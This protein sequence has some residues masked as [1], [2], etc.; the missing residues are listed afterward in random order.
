MNRATL[1]KSREHAG[2]SAHQ[3]GIHEQCATA[4]AGSLRISF[5]RLRETHDFVGGHIRVRFPQINER[6]R[7]RIVGRIGRATG[8]VRQR[9]AEGD[10]AGNGRTNDAVDVVFRAMN[11][12]IFVLDFRSIGKFVGEF[13]EVSA[14]RKNGAPART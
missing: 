14:V 5:Y 13:N 3:G 10:F 9:I 11:L 4:T 6:R 1:S 8:H 12:H 7:L 2:K